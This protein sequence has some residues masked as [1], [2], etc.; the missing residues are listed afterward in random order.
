MDSDLR[1]HFDSEPPIDLP[2]KDLS[3]GACSDVGKESEL[4]KGTQ[5]LIAKAEQGDADA[6]H[7]LGVMYA[8]RKGVSQDHK[9]AEKSMTPDQIAKAQKLSREWFEKYQPKE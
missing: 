5:S 6:Q 9:E 8:E 7:R 3:V 2:L 1:A 4:S